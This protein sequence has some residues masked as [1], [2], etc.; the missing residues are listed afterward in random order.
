MNEIAFRQFELGCAEAENMFEYANSMFGIISAKLDGLNAAGHV[1]ESSSIYTEAVS[2]MLDKIKKFFAKII[3]KIKSLAASVKESIAA[4]KRDATVKK[5]LKEV[6]KTLAKSHAEF[7][8]KTVKIL[9]TIKYMKAYDKYISTVLKNTRALYTKKYTS[10]E[11]FDLYQQKY[12]EANDKAWKDLKLD[13][14]TQ[15]DIDISLNAAYTMTQKELAN[16]DAINELYVKAWQDAVEA[17]QKQAEEV[18]E[19]IK[20]NP[21][22]AASNMLSG[23]RSSVSNLNNRLTPAMRVLKNSIS[24]KLNTIVR[25]IGEVRKSKKAEEPETP[26]ED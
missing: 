15:Y 14:V 19:Q 7:N 18:C 22:Q 16:V 11:E 24:N 1:M 21:S 13:D 25:A 26:A 12:F 5:A 9:D 23:I 3:E 2:D 8:G 10:A 20:D 4:Y 6:E 17:C